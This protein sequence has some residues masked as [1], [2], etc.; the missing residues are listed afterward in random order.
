MRASVSQV[1][2]IEVRLDVGALH[3]GDV[4]VQVLSVDDVAIFD[5]LHVMCTKAFGE[6]MLETT[7][8][9]VFTVFIVLSA[10]LKS[11]LTLSG[12]AHGT[13]TPH[14][15]YRRNANRRKRRESTWRKSFV[16]LS[17]RNI[18]IEDI[19]ACPAAPRLR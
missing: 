11:P 14:R 19:P 17:L 10:H 5:H 8:G 9:R 1:A 15:P 7:C 6:E 3:V 18:R 13:Q 16:A 2:L 4:R 12:Q